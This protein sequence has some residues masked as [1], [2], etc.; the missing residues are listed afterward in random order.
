MHRISRRSF[1]SISAGALV[2]GILPIS[3]PD[4]ATH[5]ATRTN[6]QSKQSNLLVILADDLGYGDL[7]SYGAPDLQTPNIDRLAA[8]G[9]RFDNFYAN[10]PVCSPTRA[11]LMTG[12][13]PEMVGVP[14]VIR[15]DPKNSWGYLSPDCKMLPS[16]LKS[17]GYRTALI[18]KWH[19]GLSSPNLPNE[20]GFYFFRG[21]LGD[22][23]DDYYAHRRHGQN[24]M[25]RDH[26]VIDPTG[27]ATDLFTGW[28]CEY[29]HHQ[30]GGRPFFLYLAYNAPHVPTQP[31]QE[32]LDK[33]QKR[34]PDMDRKRAR[35]CTLIEHMDDGLGRV[36]AALR[37]TGLEENTL[38]IFTSDNGGDLGA[39]ARNGPVRAG[40]GTLYEGGIRV[41][42]AVCWPGRIK[43]GTRSSHVALTMD[44][45]PTLLD[46]AG[47][48]LP[49][50]VDGLS[51]LPTLMGQQ[52][53][54]AERDLFFGRREGGKGFDGGTIECIRRGDWKLLRSRPGGS[55]EL[56]NLRTDPL[57]K[58]D[59][60][61]SEPQKVR[62]LSAA[63]EAQLERYKAV[64]WQPPKL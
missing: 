59:L 47:V 20:R 54:E 40:K 3:S 14:G 12:R 49:E 15:T 32:W 35:L 24:Y 7:S 21:F 25:R 42:A 51:F 52:Q 64:P 45:M 50:K 18:G 10:C 17:A 56:Y 33:V 55:L 27:H 29:L 26:H 37:E 30:K 53:P 46:A 5:A 2:G 8:E 23:M 9:M 58:K 39:G 44:L 38:V 36:M 4:Q 22:M 60:A 34:R 48:P 1:V 62:E 61:A 28:A 13:Y 41:P 6:E 63:L 57:E 19:L 16:L 31:P 43:A 11:S